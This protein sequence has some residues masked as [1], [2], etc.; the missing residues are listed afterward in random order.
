MRVYDET[1]ERT[2][3]TPA[4]AMTGLAA[5]SQGSK[6][7]C[8]WRVRLSPDVAGPTHAIDRDQVWVPVSGTFAFTVGDE[9]ATVGVGQAVL[10]PSGALRQITVVEAPAEAIV[11]MAPGGVA[12]VP[13]NDK[14]I[15]LPWAE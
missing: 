13:G 7:V 12:T 15:P 3:R 9:T 2:T 10:L 4:G 14:S 6:E 11:S 1:D 5:P 8:V